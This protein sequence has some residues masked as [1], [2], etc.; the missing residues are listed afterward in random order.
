MKMLMAMGLVCGVAGLA[1]AEQ[2]R[3][4]NGTDLADW[5]SVADHAITG[6]YD[7]PEPTWCVT[8][9]CIRTTG[10]PFGYLR[11]KRT[12]FANFKLHVEYRWWRKTEKPNSGV[13]VRLAVDRGTFIPTAVENQLCVGCAGDVLGLAGFAIAGVEPRD[14][15]EPAKPLSGITKVPRKGT[16][17]EKPFGEW[18]VLEV[19]LKGDTLVNWLNGVEQNRVTG[20][21]VKSG[22]I[23]LQSEGGAAEF[24]NVWVEPVEMPSTDV[25]VAIDTSLGEIELV[26]DAEKAPLTVANFIAYVTSGHYTDTIFHR[27][28][29][30]F[31]IQGG[32]FTSDMA[33]KTTRTPVKNEAAN[34]LKNTRGTIAMA[35]TMVV[36]SATSQFFIN[37]K[38]NAFLDYRAPNARD[39]GYCVFGRVTK[40]LE[41]VDKIAQVKTGNHG[42]HQNVPVEPVVIRG[43]RVVK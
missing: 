8:N 40:G 30:G 35:R 23:A 25:K 11:T 14:A 26:L 18:N 15:Y 28:I 24:R 32:G 39:F 5:T 38:D 34:G 43:V 17:S 13:F 20:L 27:V 1:G 19:E 9:G 6:G 41:V 2:V 29:P 37:L 7:A 10:T 31:M 22:A 12:D 42:F 16:E 36:D 21:S 4:F 33:Q 3:L